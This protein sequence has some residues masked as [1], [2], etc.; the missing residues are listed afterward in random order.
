[1]HQGNKGGRFPKADTLDAPIKL[2]VEY[3]YLR[4]VLRA[5]TPGRP[6]D[7]YEINPLWLSQNSQYPQKAVLAIAQAGL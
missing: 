4:K 6:S 7:G 1:M 2:L 3:G 5:N